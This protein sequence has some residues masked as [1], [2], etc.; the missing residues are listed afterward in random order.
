MKLRTSILILPCIPWAITAHAGPH[1]SANYT[2]TA[3]TT[4]AGGRRTTSTNYTNDGSAGLIAGI[5]TVASPAETA[6]AGYIAQ[7]SEVAGLLVNASPASV[8]EL[9]TR[10]LA[11]WQLLDDAS[12]LEVSPTAVA[13]SVVAGPLTGISAAGLASA[14]P[15]YQNTPATVQGSFAGLSD[16]FALT[17]LNVLPDNFGS[18]AGDGLDDSWQNQYFGQNNPA[19]APGADPDGDGQD[20]RFEF[21]AGLEPTDPASRFLLRIEPVAGQPAH[22]RLIFSPR[23]DGRTYNILT[24]TT[25]ATDSWSA[26]TG[27]IV[28]DNGEERSVT[29]TDATEG[30]KFYRV[31][32]VNP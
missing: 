18:Y 11:A 28:S 5:A 16:G 25:L 10:Q 13:W 23:F 21:T 3:D 24:S 31:Q 4:D 30:K 17:V 2:V 15:V 26:L 19:A 6:K 7:L 20:N 14:G 1:T 27:G 22:K 29:D 12:Y 9:A 8:D 32:V